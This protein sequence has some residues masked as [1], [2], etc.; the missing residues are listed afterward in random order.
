MFSMITPSDAAY[1]ERELGAP[2]RGIPGATAGLSEHCLD[3]AAAAGC[4]RLYADLWRGWR[5]ST[6]S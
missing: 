4:R 5:I 6:P 2:A 3:I 1:A